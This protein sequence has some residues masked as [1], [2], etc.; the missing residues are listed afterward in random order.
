MRV[1]SGTARGRKLKPLPGLDTRPTTDK[2]KE[3][4]FSILQFDLEGRR[5]LDLF[6]GTGQLGIEALSCGAAHAD[7]VD[8]N[9]QS[10][11]IIRENLKA[12]GVGERAEVFAADAQQFLNPAMKGKYGIVLLDPPYGGEVLNFF[13]QKITLFDIVHTG[14]IILCEC[15]AADEI[16]PPAAPYELMRTYRY[17]AIRLMTIRR[18]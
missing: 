9:P 18:M 3:S 5:V 6:A 1:I 4:M 7:F 8:K 17:G 15:A 2:V 16:I 13:L 14:G 12:A 11:K 10:V